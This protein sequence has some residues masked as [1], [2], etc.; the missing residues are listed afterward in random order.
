MQISGSSA[1][2]HRYAG[3]VSGDFRN[4][5]Y[6]P[7]QNPIGT[8]LSPGDLAK[9]STTL[10]SMLAGID[11][12]NISSQE[13]ANLGSALYQ[14]GEISDNTAIN[15]VIGDTSQ[16]SRD[17]K[18]DAIAYFESI[19]QL[20]TSDRSLYRSRWV[21]SDILNAVYNVDDVI[22]SKGTI[23]IKA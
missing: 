17:K 14:A 2:I 6:T 22:R 4:A 7:A 3:Q 18:F 13:L 20:M 11:L 16:I 10:Q 15:M 9:K 5:Y 19:Y 8:N 12:R 23:D 21:Y 1:F